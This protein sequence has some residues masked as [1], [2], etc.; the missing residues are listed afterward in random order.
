ML[1]GFLPP[2]QIDLPARGKNGGQRPPKLVQK[3]PRQIGSKINDISKYNE[4]KKTQIAVFGLLSN[5]KQMCVINWADT[6]LFVI[7]VI[8][9]NPLVKLTRQI[10]LSSL[11]V[12]P[13]FHFRTVDFFD[14]RVD[15]FAKCFERD[16]KSNE[17]PTLYSLQISC[18]HGAF[19]FT[20]FTN[21]YSFRLILAEPTFER[22]RK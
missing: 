2:R 9:R 18:S 11:P 3:S 16:V 17:L 22:K 12:I 13:I 19:G 10:Q 1:E 21:C 6:C 20:S 7:L 4:N 14:L 15:F 8:C 5:T